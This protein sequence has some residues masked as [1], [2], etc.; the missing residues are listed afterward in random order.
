MRF[1]RT[2]RDGTSYG[3]QG[4]ERE[5][6]LNAITNPGEKSGPQGSAAAYAAMH[7]VLCAHADKD[8]RAAHWPQPGQT[9]ADARAGQSTETGPDREAG[10]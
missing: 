4:A 3:P 7:P 6:A 10:Q 2:G 9:C 8:G 1:Q 5:Q